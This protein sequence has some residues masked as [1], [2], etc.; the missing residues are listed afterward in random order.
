LEVFVDHRE[1]LN[2][3]IENCCGKAQTHFENQNDFVS[4]ILP[5]SKQITITIMLTN[6]MT[7]VTNYLT[8]SATEIPSCIKL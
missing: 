3:K 8:V 4:N 7:I 5:K 1:N 6:F 2:C